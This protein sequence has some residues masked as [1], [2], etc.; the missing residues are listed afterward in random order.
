MTPPKRQN[1]VWLTIN[2]V[3]AELR[4]SPKTLYKVAERDRSF[5]AIRVGGLL[6]ISL[7]RLER[8]L[9]RQHPSRNPLRFSPDAVGKTGESADSPR[10]PR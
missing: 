8:W 10:A 5:P 9:E 7:A 2:E 6:R 1:V 4:V 3:A